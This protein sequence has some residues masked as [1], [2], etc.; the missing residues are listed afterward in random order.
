MRVGAAHR[1]LGTRG[2]I[3]LAPEYSLVP[4]TLWLQR[5]SST[6]LPA[7]AHPWYKAREGLWW[8]GKVAHRTSTYNSSAKS[9]IVR[10]LDDPGPIEIDPLPLFYTTSRSAVHGPWCLQR[11]Q[12]GGLARG[13]LR[14]PDGPCGDPPFPLSVLGNWRQ[15]RLQC[16]MFR[17]CFCFLHELSHLWGALQLRCFNYATFRDAVPVCPFPFLVLLYPRP[18][19]PATEFQSLAVVSCS[20]RIFLSSDVT[21]PGAPLPMPM[22]PRHRYSVAG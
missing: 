8:L 17:L 11:H 6:T 2:E 14:S 9:C 18:C 19:V 16:F 22:R 4:R 15:P 3:F 12:A 20:A 10:F 21:F 5:F 7:G 1:E 13:V